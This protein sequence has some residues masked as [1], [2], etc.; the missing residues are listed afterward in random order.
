VIHRDIKPENILLHDGTP[1][2]ADFGI[3]LALSVAGGDRLTETGLSV[4]TPQYMSPEQATA[5]RDLT[6]K[7]DIY[8]LGAVL[9]ETLTGEPPHTGA[10]AQATIMQIVADEPRA[11]TDLRKSVP[12]HIAAATAK[13][14][15][16]IPGDRFDSAASFA[17][18]LTDTKVLSTQAVAAYVPGSPGTQPS[19]FW[20]ARWRTVIAIVLL[21]AAAGW[22]LRPVP[23]A[24]VHPVTRFTIPVPDGHLM[25]FYYRPNIDVSPDGRS[26][27]FFSKSILYRRSLDRAAPDRLGEFPEMC[28]PQFSPDRRWVV[29]GNTLSDPS[30]KGV[31][32]EG[33]P[34]VD[35]V[36]QLSNVPLVIGT[37]MGGGVRRRLPGSNEWE[38]ITNPGTL[39]EGA[40]AWAQLMPEERDVLFTVLGPSYM[41]HGAA[42]V[43]E[44]IETGARDTVVQD[45]TYGRYLPTGH[46]VYVDV[47][48]TLYAV[49]YDAELR[50]A[51]GT[52]FVVDSG[53]RTAYWG[54]GA[55]YAVSN[56]GTLAFVRGSS[57]ENHRLT[58][59][60]RS[61]NVIDRV[62]RPV[63]VEGVR[64]SPDG[65]YVVT[66]VASK[67]AD[68]FLFDLE[69]GQDR[70]LTFDPETEDNPVWSPDGQ[71]IAYRQVISSSEDRIYI[72]DIA[73]LEQPQ[74]V[75]TTERF[76]APRAWSP[77]G[78]SLLLIQE[79]SL[80]VLD[81]ETGVIDTVSTRAATEG[82][83]FSPDGR[84]LA[85][86]SRETGEF[87]V[88]VVSF[89]ELSRQHQV[90]LSGGRRPE[91][92]ADSGELFFVDADTVK[93]CDV[94]TGTTFSRSVP[95]PLFVSSDFENRLLWYAVSADG[96]RLLYP[97]PN[98]EAEANEIHVVLNWFE[99]LKAMSR[100]HDLGIL[101]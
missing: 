58:W 15:E 91:W 51:T 45:A 40:H 83:R 93:V 18:A 99:E 98:S 80:L 23:S 4:G 20:R 70:R 48:G 89:P 10:T 75:Y 100:D 41:W 6:T 1:M 73:G 95:R 55:S 21:A 97:A 7:S 76:T 30:I 101:N 90:S 25:S 19:Q 50:R 62:G 13:A 34:M 5:D 67:N 59:I 77:D 35:L 68:I 54:G 28:C 3:A 57:W 56:S 39:G 52:P 37:V 84:W 82:G 78:G 29:F 79:G 86:T 81:L 72:R 92:S 60:D 85:Y 61:G 46:I 33:G 9:Y 8:S 63:T 36:A 87:E 49:P 17:A 96:R 74:L 38:A 64:L 71:R 69:T 42:V 47:D 43:V 88:Y 22:F 65:R 24:H 11:V 53:I 32:I 12:A 44:D 94:S 2:V 14:L 26:L 27:V 66:Y 31:S 16:K